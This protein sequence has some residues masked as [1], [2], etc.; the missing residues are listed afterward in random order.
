MGEH[1]KIVSIIIPVYNVE[2]YLAECLD[3]VIHQTYQG[4]E[5]ICVNDRSTDR[6][7]EILRE[8]SQRDHRI[9]VIQNQCNLGQAS[10]RNIGLAT[11]TGDY[12]LF[13]D[14]DDWLDTR[15]VEKCLSCIEQIQADFV[16]FG[17]CM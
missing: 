16:G 5:I 4:L 13:L 17:L 3:S 12:I 10:S 2:Q 14:S 6:S 15:T 1:L 8:Y 7:A 11:A 9:T